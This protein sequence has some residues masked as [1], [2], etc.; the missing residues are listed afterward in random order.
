MGTVPVPAPG[1]DDIDLLDL[2]DDEVD[3]VRDFLTTRRQA[4]ARE[5]AIEER[6]RIARESAA[7]VANAVG[8]GVLNVFGATQNSDLTEGKG[9]SVV[10]GWFLL[11]EDADLAHRLLEGVMGTENDGRVSEAKVYLSVEDWLADGGEKACSRNRLAR[12]RADGTIP[13]TAT[14]RR[15][16]PGGWQAG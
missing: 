13:K 11:P 10:R 5:R 12:W 2:R 15:S 8:S 4:E 3:A 7:A 16:Q 6:R 14:E 9:G 1:A